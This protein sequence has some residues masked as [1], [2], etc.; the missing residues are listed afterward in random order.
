MK[1]TIS[2]NRMLNE[3][4]L[5]NLFSSVNWDSANDT[6]RLQEAFLHSSHILTA[7]DGQKLIGIIRSMDDNVWSATIDC[8]VV[9]KD[10]QREG[11]G[12][13]LLQKLLKELQHITYISVSPND[14]KSNKFYEKFGFQTI[15]GSSLLQIENRN[16]I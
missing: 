12:S 4:Q 9:H 5:F 2:S 14:S 1:Y 7:W 3:T 15:P 16:F 10:Y 8:L 6:H 11:I 13:L